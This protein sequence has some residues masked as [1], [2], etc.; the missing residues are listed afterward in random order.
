MFVDYNYS[1]CIKK[2]QIIFLFVS[3]V[4]KKQ[5]FVLVLHKKITQFMYTPLSKTR[6]IVLLVWGMIMISC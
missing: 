3:Q 2:L 5:Q 6:S 1:G 4:R